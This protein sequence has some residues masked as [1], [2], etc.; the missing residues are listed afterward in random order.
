MV[1]VKGFVKSFGGRTVVKDIS[2]KVAEGEVV[3]LLGP[4]GAGKTTT[5]RMLSTTLAP[6][7]GTATINGFD[8]IK[9]PDKVRAS[10]GVLPTDPGL[11]GRLT[12]AE[13]LRFF[14]RLCGLPEAEL[15][16]RIERLLL[17]L[18]MTEHRDR[19]TEGF[20][21]GMKQKI[22]LARSIL[23]E[24][25]FLILDEPTAGLDVLSAQT[26]IQFIQESKAAGRSV[27]FSSHYLVE[28]ERVCDRIG[29]IADGEIKAFGTIAEV[30]QLAN[31]DRLEDAFVTLVHGEQSKPEV[32][33]WAGAQ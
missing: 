3:G 8:V 23:H 15:D 22:A 31:A 26:V 6:S 27:L 16:E 17:W 5:L 18:N 10:I 1:E 21:K 11:Y 2:F 24:P 28:A 9:Q 7:K 19:K 4:N 30:C 12:A 33:L 14:G 13:N 20:S 29:I 32:S 25:P